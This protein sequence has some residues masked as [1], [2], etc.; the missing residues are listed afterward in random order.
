M[1][2]QKGAVPTPLRAL[3]PVTGTAIAITA[4]PPAVASCKFETMY[5]SAGDDHDAGSAPA[6]L[7]KFKRRSVLECF[8]TAE[9]EP[10]GGVVAGKARRSPEL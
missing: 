4:S 9:P 6:D 3:P 5:L 10:W 7:F 1:E 2:G 8:G